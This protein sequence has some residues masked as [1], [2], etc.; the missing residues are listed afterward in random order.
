MNTGPVGQFL[1]TYRTFTRIVVVAVGALVYLSLDHPTGANAL[2][3]NACI[4][5]VLV[6]LEFLAAPARE[7]EVDL[8][9]PGSG[10]GTR[11]A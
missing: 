10:L 8:T 11:H 3:I 9:G 7:P 4:V 6:V 2:V 5:V 1:T